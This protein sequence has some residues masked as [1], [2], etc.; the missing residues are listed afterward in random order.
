MSGTAERR[1]YDFM[2]KL[3]TKGVKM[4]KNNNS[5]EKMFE[6]ELR[7]VASLVKCVYFKIPDPIVTR[8]R[9]KED[10]KG[11]KNFKLTEERRPFDS[12]LV[13]PSGTACVECKYNYNGLLEHQ[14]D[15]LVDVTKINGMAYVLQKIEKLDETGYRR[16]SVKYRAKKY[17]GV[18][19]VTKCEYNSPLD[20]IKWIIADMA[21][22]M[23]SMSLKQ[24]DQNTHL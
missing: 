20:L 1:G 3:E 12:V 8:D 10:G 2:A 7:H 6:N 11:R 9:I 13:T 5:G 18:D 16:L 23:S 15:N 19:F 22:I 17:D 24:I 21:E 14:H 4:K